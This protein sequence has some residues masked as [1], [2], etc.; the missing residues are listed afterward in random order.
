MSSPSSPDSSQS[1][2][3]TCFCPNADL[4]LPIYDI[5]SLCLLPAELRNLVFN[6]L[7]ADTCP[8][9]TIALARLS[10]HHYAT[11]IPRLYRRLV[12]TDEA[13]DQGLFEGLLAGFDEDEWEGG[14][15]RLLSKRDLLGTCESLNFASIYAMDAT[16]DA[17]RKAF[18]RKQAQS[19]VL[20]N[21]LRGLFDGVTHLGYE[22]ECIVEYCQL[23]DNDRL[24]MDEGASR[25]GIRSSKAQHPALYNLSH[26]CFRLPYPL[27][28]ALSDD[29]SDFYEIFPA[30]G[31]H[32]RKSF[33]TRF[34]N[35]QSDRPMTG[36]EWTVRTGH[37]MIVDML[38]TEIE[39]GGKVEVEVLSHNMVECCRRII[40][41]ARFDR[42]YGPPEIIFT[43]LGTTLSP[44]GTVRHLS[45]DVK[46]TVLDE[47]QTVVRQRVR[48]I[49]SEDGL[50]EFAVVADK[51]YVRGYE[52]CKMCPEVA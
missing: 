19:D 33:V 24:P 26:V 23:E 17:C 49:L 3:K 22:A 45:P 14:E 8:T 42:R 36:V 21:G 1:H 27:H 34:H 31:S 46:Q 2:P 39:E 9:H 38:P 18:E 47:T 43:N 25:Y 37:T 5:T 7:T 44:D 32:A 11:L 16:G 51:I 6:F 29:I 28:S 52:A 13:L 20:C 30:F 10:K 4:S 12:V 40:C 48:E 15:E 41:S 50:S 35:C